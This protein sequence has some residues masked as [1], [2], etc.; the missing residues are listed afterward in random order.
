MAEWR[1]AKVIFLLFKIY[2]FSILLIQ[3][4]RVIVKIRKYKDDYSISVMCQADNKS[5][6]TLSYGSFCDMEECDIVFMVNNCVKAH[7]SAFFTVKLC[8]QQPLPLSA[9]AASAITIPTFLFFLTPTM[10][11]SVLSRTRST[12]FI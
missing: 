3:L 6:Y 2:V 10:L 12:S 1:N 11:R 5:N 9:W 8:Q 4:F 7:W